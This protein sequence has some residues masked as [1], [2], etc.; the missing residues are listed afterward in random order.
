M[1]AINPALRM[2]EAAD[3]IRLTEVPPGQ[4]GGAPKR[5]Y[6]VNPVLHEVE[7]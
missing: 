2:L 1:D 4:K 3:L 6:S 5:L 7:T